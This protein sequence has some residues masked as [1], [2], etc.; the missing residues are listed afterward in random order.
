M[1]NNFLINKKPSLLGAANKKTNYIDQ[2]KKTTLG[3][4]PSTS[5]GT[6]FGNN[7]NSLILPGSDLEA[8]PIPEP[9]TTTTTT[10]TTTSTTTIAP[11]TT[12]STT[13][14]TTTGDGYYYGLAG[15]QECGTC[16][17]LGNY[18]PVK[19][20][21][22]LP[23]YGY[24]PFLKGVDGKVYSGFQTGTYN[25]N[26]VEL[27]NVQYPSCAAVPCN[28]TTTTT[29]TTTSTTTTIE[30]TFLTTESGDILTTDTG[31]ELIIG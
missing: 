4:T 6:A 9:T 31:L 21:S 18:L 17:W 1:P 26:A 5:A 14:S 13:T 19:S 7:Q 24:S 11:T 22:P 15:Q 10:S 28:T 25:V 29:S 2:F 3:Y 27:I 16:N 20:L 8:N 23:A 30:P 12:T